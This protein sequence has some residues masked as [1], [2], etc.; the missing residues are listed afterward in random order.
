MDVN[1]QTTH[2]LMFHANQG[3]GRTLVTLHDVLPHPG[4]PVMGP[5]RFLSRHERDGIVS[6]LTGKRTGTRRLLPPQVL[7]Q[8][9]GCLL[10]EVPGRVRPMYFFLR[11][12]RE[13]MQAPWPRLLLLAEGRSLRAATVVTE[14][15][16]DASTPLYH[17]PLM[18]FNEE[19]RMCNGSTT[20]PA[21][22]AMDTLGEWESVLFDTAFSHISH[23]DTL[24]PDALPESARGVSDGNLAHLAFWRWLSRSGQTAFPREALVPMGC[25]LGEWIAD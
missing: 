5:G 23:S 7:M 13:S 10:W 8:E 21:Q 3:S 6:Q 22:T 16:P 9:H 11:G 18:N 25:T 1:L 20:P 24:Q 14:G 19:G 12:R 4:G 2:A 15:R 17:A